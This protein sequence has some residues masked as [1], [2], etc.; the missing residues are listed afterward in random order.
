[1]GTKIEY[2]INPLATLVDSNNLAVGGV[3]VWE[4][5]QNKH[6][7]TGIN[8]LQGPMDRMLDRNNIESI[9]N[10]MQ[11]H[12]DIFK[13]Q[14]RE[15]HRIY[16][17][18]KRLME[19]LKNEIRQ[20][21]FWN[22]VN[23]IDVNH[24]HSIKQHH[25]TTQISHKP[26]F[27]VQNLREDLNTREKS[28]CCSGNTIQRQRGFDLERPAEEDVFTQARGFD[29]GEAGP[30][31]NTALQSCKIS[32]TGGYDEEVEVDLTLSIGG[33][34]VKNSRLPQLA[35]SNSTKGKTRNLNS[36]G[37][38]QSDRD[39]TGECSDPTTPMSSSTVKFT[40]QGKGP[41]WLS[42]SLKLK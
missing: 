22:H 39:R 23:D 16:S 30:S 31:S 29:E 2:S 4:H 21:K 11:M 40:Q 28:V 9:K 42:Q 15:L 8:K 1:M 13:H 25:Q 24:P 32:T 41:H 35:C 19:E 17:V 27:S 10:T 3:D 37:S 7:R 34:K 5:C 14:V 12:E 18:Q 33:S 20:Q 38:F 26:D 36:S 6:Q